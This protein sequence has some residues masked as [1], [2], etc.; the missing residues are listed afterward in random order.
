MIHHIAMTTPDPDRLAR[1]YETIPGLSVIRRNEESGSL[2]S[3]WFAGDD[4]VILMIERGEAKAP[5]ALVF[6]L[7][8]RNA[9]DDAETV[10]DLS[11]IIPL[12]EERTEY[13]LYFRDPDGNRLGFSSYPD[14]LALFEI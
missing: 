3:V 9:N 12:E 4:G 1:F 7:R 6:N 11:S 13:T 5:F 2:R 8:V 10:R 14:P